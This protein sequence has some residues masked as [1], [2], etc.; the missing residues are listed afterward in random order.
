MSSIIFY[1]L[2][3]LAVLMVVGFVIMAVEAI[4]ELARGAFHQAIEWLKSLK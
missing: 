2:V 1:G 3:F 4:E